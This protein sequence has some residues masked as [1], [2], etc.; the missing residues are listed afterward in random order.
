MGLLSASGPP[1]WHL[2]PPTLKIACSRANELLEKERSTTLQAVALRFALGLG[3]TASDSVE[4]QG[5]MKTVVGCSRLEHV[6][7]CLTAWRKVTLVEGDVIMEE[8]SDTQDEKNV[9][10]EN[11]ELVTEYIRQ[12]GY[13]E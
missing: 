13:L 12:T 10:K 11:E 8:R 7:E 1:F 3:R 5:G 4:E 9:Q 2:A 6:T